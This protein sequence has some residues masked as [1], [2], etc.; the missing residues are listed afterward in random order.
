MKALAK[1]LEKKTGSLMPVVIGPDMDVVN[2]IGR[3]QV[4]AELFSFPAPKSTILSPYRPVQ[5]FKTSP[6]SL[7]K[8][9]PRKKIA[10]IAAA[11]CYPKGQVVC[12]CQ[13]NEAH[14][15]TAT[16]KKSV[17][18]EARLTFDLDYEPNTILGDI[19]PSSLKKPLP[20]LFGNTPLKNPSPRAQL[21]SASVSLV[22]R[23]L[24]TSK[25]AWR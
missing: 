13:S 25:R 17:Q 22:L 20:L 23:S 18:D 3:L 5:A 19:S 4:A 12:W 9:L 2:G 1:A 10:A 11:L 21:P 15:F 14:Q 7:K 8:S 24:Y 16:K 6:S